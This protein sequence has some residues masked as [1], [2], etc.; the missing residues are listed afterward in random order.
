[1]AARGQLY[2][3]TLRG[4]VGSRQEQGKLGSLTGQVDYDGRT[5]W[6]AVEATTPV[7][8]LAGV[9]AS[10]RYERLRVQHTLTGTNAAMLAKEAGIS[11]S[12]HQPEVLGVRLRWQPAKQQQVSLEWQEDQTDARS[13][14]RW[15]LRWQHQFSLLP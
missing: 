4:A 10:L 12:Q 15:L 1:L 5:D 7:P 11:S 14:Q 3:V 9:D 13:R 8:R 2:G 6:L